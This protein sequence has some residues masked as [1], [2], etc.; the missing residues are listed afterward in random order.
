MIYSDGVECVLS[1]H[2]RHRHIL[3]TI[4]W[5]RCVPDKLRLMDD[6]D[7]TRLHTSRMIV[8]IENIFGLASSTFLLLDP[9]S[10]LFSQKIGCCQLMRL[11]GN[12]SP[13]L[14]PSS[15]NAMIFTSWSQS[16]VQ[17]RLSPF[18]QFLGNKSSKLFILWCQHLAHFEETNEFSFKCFIFVRIVSRTYLL[19]L[20]RNTSSL[21]SIGDR[22]DR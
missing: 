12:R 22:S 21:E 6:E 5:I 19:H 3:K 16:S 10:T 14:W 8:V 17:T 7:S 2:I 4:L 1:Y 15:W 18:Q 9:Q 11:A 13:N 20:Y